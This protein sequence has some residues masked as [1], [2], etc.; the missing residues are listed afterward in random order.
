MQRQARH[1]S[2]G[3]RW[4][5]PGTWGE[6]REEAMRFHTERDRCSPGGTHA[7]GELQESPLLL[8]AN[9]EWA[10]LMPK[11]MCTGCRSHFRLK[12]GLAGGLG[13]R[14]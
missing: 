4:E 3:H 7:L 2:R 9:L 11:S 13:F 14:D 10:Q 1:S 6:L 12:A 5:C 8:K